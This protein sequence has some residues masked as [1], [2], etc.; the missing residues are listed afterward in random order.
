ML[1]SC[2]LRIPKFPSYPI[3]SHPPNPARATYS[4]K[5]TLRRQIQGAISHAKTTSK[6]FIRSSNPRT[7]QPASEQSSKQAKAINQSIKNVSSKKVSSIRSHKT[8]KRDEEKIIQTDELLSPKKKIYNPHAQAQISN[9][10]LSHPLNIFQT[11]TPM[12]IS[13]F[14]FHS[15]S[16][17]RLEGLCIYIILYSFFLSSFCCFI[18]SRV[19][20]VLYCT[21]QGIVNCL[22]NRHRYRFHR[23]GSNV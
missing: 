4:S 11:K 23:R 3:P 20:C 14:P 2:L 15:R 1:L 13:R 10:F 21:V 6:N 12:L 7:S 18:L 8:P 22:I 19:C 16:T 17:P 5:Q 9:M